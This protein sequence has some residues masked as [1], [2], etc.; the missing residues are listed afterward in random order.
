MTR[1]WGRAPI[2]VFKARSEQ[3]LW[4]WYCRPCNAGSGSQ[5]LRSGYAS[6]AFATERALLHLS[7]CHGDAP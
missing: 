5:A 3:E 1:E 7:L 6:R 2:A 4:V